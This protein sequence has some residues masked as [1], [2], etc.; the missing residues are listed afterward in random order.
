MRILCMCVTGCPDLNIRILGTED[1]LDIVMYHKEK[2]SS[3][4]TL[5]YLQETSVGIILP[6]A[7]GHR[8]K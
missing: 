7:G 1:L 2:E 3:K 8:A 4:G 5:K 6:G